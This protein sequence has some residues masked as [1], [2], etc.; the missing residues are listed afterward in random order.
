MDKVHNKEKILMT[1][2]VPLQKIPSRT[3]AEEIIKKLVAVGQISLS[4]HCKQRMK[5]RDITMQQVLTCLTKGRIT[6]EPFLTHINGGG[7]ETTIE[8]TVA[9]DHLRIGVCLKFTQRVLVITAIKY[10]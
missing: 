9:G 10:K 4:T 8:R 1:N 7:Y 3:E 6:D 5:E 2:I